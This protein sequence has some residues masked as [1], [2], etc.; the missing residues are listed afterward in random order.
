MTYPTENI[1]LLME[2][3]DAIYEDAVKRGKPFTKLS[4]T[5][6]KIV[7]ARGWKSA[8]SFIEPNFDS[9]L[10]ELKIFYV[11]KALTPGPMF[12]FPI[13][14]TE[15]EYNYAQTKPLEGSIYHGK[16]YYRLGVEPVGPQW[17]G[18]SLTALRN[19]VKLGRVAL[20]EGPFD[21]LACRLLVPAAPVL[22][23]LTKTIGKDHIAY[24][25]MLGIEVTCFLY[26]NEADLK[27]YSAGRW[28][29]KD[30]KEIPMMKSRVLACP[31]SD[32]SQALR[33]YNTALALKSLLNRLLSSL[34]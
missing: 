25:R 13:M 2:K 17:L 15:G 6:D 19:I 32:P 33:N 28:Q 5:R 26:D 30:I 7:E 10:T 34:T 18:N 20:V 12:V 24:L 11:P 8:L 1:P 23:P 4:V 31:A 29:S 16:K 22:C 3:T 14:D 27:G 9:V 21:L